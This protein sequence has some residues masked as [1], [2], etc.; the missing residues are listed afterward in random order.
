[1]FFGNNKELE[2]Q[3]DNANNALNKANEKITHYESENNHLKQELENQINETQALQFKI[4]KLEQELLNKNDISNDILQDSIADS[5]QQ[6]FHN[7]N[8]HLKSSLLDI[9]GNIAE[10]TELSRENL[11]TSYEIKQIYNEASGDLEYIVSNIGSLDTDAKEINDVV[12]QLDSKAKNI[13]EAVSMIHD[14]V[15]QINILSLNAAVE[16]ASAGEAGKGFAVVAQEVK[17]LANRT[18]DA[19]KNI[20][21]V[22][23]TIQSSVSQTNERFNSITDSIEQI[24]QKTETY[25]QGIQTVMDKSNTSFGNLAHITDRVFMSLAKLD[26]VIW[27]VNTYFSVAQKEPAFEFVNHKNCRLGKWYSEGLGK[28][29]FSATPSYGQLDLPHSQVHNA[30][31]KVFDSISTDVVDFD[32]AISALEEMEEASYKVFNLLDIIL[33]ERG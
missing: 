1:M 19:A 24:A 22:A 9:Q 2:S 28:R 16:A 29:Y 20:E 27:K 11:S 12:M 5:L 21:E 15:L 30:T 23:A 6:V 4:Q 7:Q 31:H 18:A 32:H 8:K 3:L 33:H 13:T 17:N 10:S 14:I 26:H 25:S